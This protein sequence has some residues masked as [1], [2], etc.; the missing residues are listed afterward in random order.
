MAY[1]TG[2]VWNEAHFSDAELDE[3]IEVAGSSLDEAE[4]VEAYHEIQRILIERGP[5]IIPYFFAQFGVMADYVEG[6]EVHP[7]AGRTNFHGASV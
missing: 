5:V 2:A 1:K 7:F 3:W 6:V 4:R